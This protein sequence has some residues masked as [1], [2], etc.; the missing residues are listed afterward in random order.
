MRRIFSLIVAQLYLE[1][2]HEFQNLL[3]QL[4]IFFR[5]QM[6]AEAWNLAL[7]H[8]PFVNRKRFFILMKARRRFRYRAHAQPDQHA[9]SRFGVALKVSMQRSSPL[10]F[11]GAE[12]LVYHG[13]GHTP[14]WED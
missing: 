12:L 13:V 1:S 2:G 5:K 14:R 6:A 3:A 11:G 8:P 7:L 4:S 9:R 10:R